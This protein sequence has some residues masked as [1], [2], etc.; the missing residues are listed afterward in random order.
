MEAWSVGKPSGRPHKTPFTAALLRV[1]EK[2]IVNDPDGSNTS[3]VPF[4]GKNEG[5]LI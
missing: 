5:K 4:E 2:E 1:V 3:R